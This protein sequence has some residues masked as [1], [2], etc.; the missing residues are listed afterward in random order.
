M[1]RTTLPLAVALCCLVA[2]PGLAA[3]PSDLAAGMALQVEPAEVPVTMFYNGTMVR[4]EATVAAGRDL[5]FVCSGGEGEVH[6]KHKGKVWGFL[7]MSVGEA[8]LDRVP[9]YY[10]VVSTRPLE[11]LAPPAVLDQL[12][13]GFGAIESRVAAGS[14]DPSM[15]QLLDELIKLKQEEGL[16]RSVSSGVEVEP[17]EGGLERASVGFWLPA[18]APFGTY[19]VD[20]LA[21]SDGVGER[22]AS[23]SFTVRTVG[24]AAFISS[25]SRQH[26]LLYGVLAVVVALAVG[27]LTGVVFGL[28]AKKAH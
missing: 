11:A 21:F 13:L 27:F 14:E 1:A 17:V 3:P 28:G 9:G 25:L 12:G 8:H 5:V 22:L 6:L 20:L 15:G 10:D 4:V 18:K 16:Y 19:E 7:W 26:G 2:S 24:L 23:G